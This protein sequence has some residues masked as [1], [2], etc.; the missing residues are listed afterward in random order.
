MTK[1]PKCPVNYRRNWTNV[2]NLKEEEEERG[3]TLK[4]A[5][6]VINIYRLILY[7]KKFTHENIAEI[8]NVIKQKLFFLSQI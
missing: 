4:V 2:G 6:Q 5:F 1:Q 3:N 8:C 7:S